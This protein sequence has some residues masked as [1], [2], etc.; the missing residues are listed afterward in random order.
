MISQ[1]GTAAV[2]TPVADG[3]LIQEIDLVQTAILAV[4]KTL[5]RSL[6]AAARKTPAVARI[7]NESMKALADLHRERDALEE[8]AGRR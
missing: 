4:N 6:W 7:V 1:N 5:N 8:Q 3:D 2:P